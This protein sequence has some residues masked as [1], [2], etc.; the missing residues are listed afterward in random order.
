[1]CNVCQKVF[2]KSAQLRLHSQIHY[3]ERP[4]KCEEC[5]ISFRSR[6]HLV[7]HERSETH[8]NKVNINQTFG[9]PSETNPRPFKCDNCLIRFRIHGHLAKHLRS[10]SHIMKLECSDKLPIGMYTEMERLQTNVTLIDTTNCETALLSLQKLAE[11]LY[12]KESNKLPHLRTSGEF[13]STNSGVQTVKKEPKESLTRLAI[14]PPI[15]TQNDTKDSASINQPSEIEDYSEN[16]VNLHPSIGRPTLHN[17]ELF[18][19]AQAINIKPTT[20]EH[21]ATA[22][23]KV[24]RCELCNNFLPNRS[25]LKKVI[26]SMLKR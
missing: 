26:K 6:G 15:F 19:A 16:P 25:D 24:F 20:G 11:S 1:M 23:D 14:K 10:K 2:S 3:M 5:G 12:N 8:R 21:R 7:K 22:E 17:S 18:H 9:A 13:T 4:F